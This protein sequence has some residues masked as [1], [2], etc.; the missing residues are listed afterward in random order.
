M[1]T[2]LW[3]LYRLR[4]RGSVRALARKFKSRRGAAMALFTLLVFGMMLGPNLV[5]AF[6]LGRTGVLARSGVLARTGDLLG[7][8]VPVMMFLL[9]VLG[10]VT[11]PGGRA[12]YFLSSEVDFLFPAPFSRRQILVYK[13]LGNITAAVYIALIFPLVLLP[14]IRCWAAAAAGCFLGFLMLNSLAMCANL[15][16]QTV[17]EGAFTRTRKLLLGGV[18]VAAAVALGQA[19]AQGL[20]APWQ[21]TLLRVR[22]AF[23]AEIVLAPFAVFAKII[24][25]GRLVPDA[26]GWVALGAIMVVGVY[27][28]AIRLDANY[29]ETAA[30]VSR[31]M[32]KRIRRTMNDGIFALQAGKVRSWRLPQPPWMGGVGPLVWR[33][34]IQARRGS[35]GTMIMM[36][37]IAAAFGLPLALS[38]HD[39]SALT[40]ILPHA[41]IGVAAY[42]AVL[43][44]AQARLGFNGDYERMDLLK[45]LPVRPMAMACGQTIV[46]VLI[47]TLLQWSM[48][49]AT[50]IFVPAGTTEMLVA[51]LLILPFDWILCGTE[52]FLFLLYPAPPVVTGSEGFLKMGRAML[53]MLTKSLAIV[54]CGAVAAVPAAVVYFA[55]QSVLE[56]CLAGWLTLLLPSFGLLLLVAW[57]FQRYDVSGGASE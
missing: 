2:A 39:R 5:L 47:L 16:A 48:F 43:Y 13:I 19:A 44:S 17:T 23:A 49:A 37:I 31:Q 55:T 9:A 29:L 30:R 22:H 18:L 35:R 52:N 24:T 6:T 10:V 38:V 15:V 33:Q 21:E 34:V 20:D 26:L 46:V 45:S 41:I 57:A 12:L 1:H 51:G 25:A 27:A 40:A 28:L 56:A 4:T 32:Q 50:A 7:E 53:F 8:A 14:Y 42:M 54:A 3:K 36:A 11:S